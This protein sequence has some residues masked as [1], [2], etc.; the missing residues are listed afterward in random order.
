[1]TAP[2]YQE[3]K[4]RS[5]VTEVTD[6]DGTRVRVITRRVL[7]PARPGRGHRRRSPQYVDISVP[8]GVERTIPVE[9]SR[10]VFAYVFEGNG[11]FRDASAPRA[12][13]TDVVTEGGLLDDDTR[14][15][16]APTSPTAR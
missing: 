7:G 6:D 8:A 12:V 2:R 5:D 15:A 1:M 14:H 4:R 13:A 9:R 16:T 10:N 11:R 3:V